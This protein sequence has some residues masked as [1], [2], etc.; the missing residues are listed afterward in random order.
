MTERV[1]RPVAFDPTARA[2]LRREAETLNNIAELKP[3]QRVVD[4]ELKQP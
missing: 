1:S 3:C 4:L 2:T